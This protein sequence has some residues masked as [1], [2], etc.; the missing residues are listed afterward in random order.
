MLAPY[1]AVEKEPPEKTNNDRKWHN[2]PL[3]LRMRL[4]QVRGYM[5]IQIA[6]HFRDPNSRWSTVRGLHFA[7]GFESEDRRRDR[8]YAGSKSD[9]HG[10]DAIEVHGLSDH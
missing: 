7:A 2:I 9:Y 6:I 4:V 1:R 10:G 5:L 3:L 8:G